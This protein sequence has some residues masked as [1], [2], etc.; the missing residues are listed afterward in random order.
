MAIDPK[1]LPEDPTA[2]RQIVIGLL[3]E[4]ETKERRLR[5]LQHW[6]EQLLRARYGPRRERVDEHQ[7]F[8]FAAAI[9]AQGGKTPPAADETEAPQSDSQTPP[10]SPGH[11][12]PR[13]PKSLRRERRVYQSHFF[14]GRR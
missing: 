10:S 9:L 5:Q 12:R 13:L 4:V 8:L 6:V 14:S 11:G 7:L 3:E 1:Q 2:L